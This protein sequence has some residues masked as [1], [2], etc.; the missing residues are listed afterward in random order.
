MFNGAP[1]GA[2]ELTVKVT[3]RQCKI[4]DTVEE[5]LKAPLQL[6]WNKA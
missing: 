5:P 2:L 4:Y 1:T 6:G 3:L